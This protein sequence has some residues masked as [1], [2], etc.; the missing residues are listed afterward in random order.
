MPHPVLRLKPKEGR[1]AR[2]GSPWVF[3][4]EIVM[5]EAARAAQPGAL[6]DLMLDDGQ[7]LGTAIFNPKTLI[8]A[9]ILGRER[10]LALDAAFFA[11]R[12]RRAAAVRDALFET[13]YYRLAHAE[14]DG[15]PGLV[16][17]RYGD[18][19]CV[20]QSAAGM[21]LASDAIVAALRDVFEAKAIVARNDVHART[22]EGLPSETTIL[23]GPPPATLT[24]EENGARFAVD[25]VHGQKTG[26]FYDQRANRAFAARFAKGRAVLDAFCHSGGFGLAALAAGATETF[27]VD[28]SEKALGLAQSNAAANGVEARSFFRK[29]DVF[30]ALTDMAT[31]GLKFGLVVCDPPAF[32]KSRKDVDAAARAYRKLA[33]EAAAVTE[34]GGV[35]VLNT[36]SHHIDAERFLTEC[37]AG[38]HAARRSA[39]LLRTGG[40]DADHP[41]HP[42]LP[43]TAYLKSL[44]FALD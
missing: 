43:E 35:L 33:R 16:I 12:L 34:P 13:P 10:G 23:H 27:F 22:L 9:R 20:Q 2:S 15:L 24:L 31:Q 37:A 5:D 28:A 41:V 44:T 18:T 7:P 11:A 32:A 25:P 4:N 1:R 17:D 14:A 30:E 19:F 8:A 40:A 38:L 21:A 29:A 6:V 39:R 26:W 3:S 42:H 36:C